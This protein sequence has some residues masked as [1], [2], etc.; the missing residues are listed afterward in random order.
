[1]SIRDLRD[2]VVHYDRPGIGRI[3]NDLIEAFPKGLLEEVDSLKPE[4]LSNERITRKV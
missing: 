3:K 4:F 1:M 2:Y